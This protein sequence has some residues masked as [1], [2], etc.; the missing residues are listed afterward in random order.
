MIKAKKAMEYIDSHRDL[1]TGVSDKVW[2]YAEMPFRETKSS[3]IIA[4]TLEAE[5]F[6]IE[7]GLAGMPTA[8]VATWGKGGPVLG[9]LGEY[10]ALIDLSQKAV[11]YKE[12]RV[13]GGGGHACG[14]NLLGVAP[15]AAAIALKK[16]MEANGVR[17]TVKYYGCPAEEAPGGGKVYMAKDGLFAECDACLCWHPRSWTRVTYASTLAMNSFEVTFHGRSAAASTGGYN[18]RSALD[19]AQLMNTAVEYLREH[20]IGKARIHYVITKGGEQPNV[21]PALA[22]VRY[23]V[24]CPDVL[25]LRALESRVLKCAAGAAEMTETTYEVKYLGGDW[26]V[27]NNTVLEGVLEDSMK[28]VGPPVFGPEEHKFAEEIAKT[29]EDRDGVLKSSP[30]SPQELRF[31]KNRN[32]C[33]IILPTMPRTIEYDLFSTDVGDVSWTVPTAQIE[34]TCVCLGTT[35]HTWQWAAQVGMGIGHAGLITAAKIFAEAGFELM[36]NPELFEKAKAEFDENIRDAGI[37]YE[38]MLPDEKPPL[39]MFEET[40]SE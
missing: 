27:L 30:Y 12:A 28:R 7:W 15:M 3:A 13:P 37:E 32:F 17:G 21:V 14:H 33:D 8:F 39:D 36:T 20:M 29:F 38:P 16:E 34:T 2:E 18:G 19:A 5:G 6:S 11:P 40:P 22:Q 35:T 1:I 23:M 9:L 25:Q 24:R 31:L 4:S 10:D 26:N